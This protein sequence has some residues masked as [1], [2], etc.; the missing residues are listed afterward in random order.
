[1]RNVV[2][3]TNVIISAAIIPNRT[4]EKAVLAIMNDE[5]SRLYYSSEIISEYR[6]VFSHAKLNISA[7][8]QR[9]FIETTEKVGLLINP[10]KSDIPFTDETDR[11][12]YDAAKASGAALITG[13]T[14]HYPKEDF[15]MTP[16]DF[17]WLYGEDMSL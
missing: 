2:I 3:D 16:A 5:N 17:L 15:I 10:P 14:K 11:K 9:F 6:K 4:P 8:K 1:M 13:N 12:F 7:E